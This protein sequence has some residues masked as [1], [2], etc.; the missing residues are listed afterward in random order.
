MTERYL[1]P[2]LVDWSVTV[3]TI[4]T[5]VDFL[6]VSLIESSGSET[7]SP[8]IADFR[9]VSSRRKETRGIDLNTVRW[10]NDEGIILK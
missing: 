6:L 9:L 2:W 1:A 8:Q 5:V 3:R 4:E 7:E 10:E